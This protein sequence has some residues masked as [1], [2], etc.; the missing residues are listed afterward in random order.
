VE[1]ATATCQAG[2]VAVQDP[3]NGLRV[4]ALAGGLLGALVTALSSASNAWTVLLFGTLGGAAGF[5]TERRRLAGER[6]DASDDAGD[7]DDS[8]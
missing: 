3:I 8:R 6:R 1:I 2:T 7:P 5:W 4:G